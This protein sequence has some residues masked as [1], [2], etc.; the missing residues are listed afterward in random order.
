MAAEIEPNS[1]ILFS[2]MARLQLQTGAAQQA[3]K[4]L[5]PRGIVNAPEGLL[6]HEVSGMVAAQ[7]ANIREALLEHPYHADLHYRLGLLLRHE[8]DLSQAIDAFR[9]AVLISPNYLKAL[10]RLGLA[11]REDGRIDAALDVLNQALAVDP[12]SVE[13]HYQLGLM[14]ADRNEFALALDKFEYAVSLE[15]QNLDY[16]ANLALALQNMGLLDRA[17]ASWETLCQAA[18][19]AP[20][21]GA[22]C[23]SAG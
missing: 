1:T 10:T 12:E 15:P 4:Y 22:R 2:E 21:G 5:S 14:F 20:L 8:G 7:I 23:L 18:S 3:L 13:L 17:A 6:D 9:Q 11:L 19:E 16:L